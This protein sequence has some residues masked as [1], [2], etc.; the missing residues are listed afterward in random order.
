MPRVNVTIT[1]NNWEWHRSIIRPAEIRGCWHLINNNQLKSNKR[2]KAKR[3]H[4]KL[5]LG[6]GTNQMIDIQY[7]IS[8]NIYQFNLTFALG[9]VCKQR[10]AQYRY[11]I[12]KEYWWLQ[13][14][15]PDGVAP[16]A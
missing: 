16:V 4:A 10:H 2:Q 15:K 9:T 6:E 1:I 13:E 11:T 3:Q 14:K 7:S 8:K 5:F 12:N